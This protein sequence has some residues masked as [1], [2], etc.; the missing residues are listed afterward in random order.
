VALVAILWTPDP[1]QLRL[2]L[3]GLIVLT[4][5]AWLGSIFLEP[6]RAPLLR[7]EAA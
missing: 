6:L 1:W 5:L 3:G 2:L 4:E 7:S